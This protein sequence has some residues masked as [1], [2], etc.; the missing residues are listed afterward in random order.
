MV[1]AAKGKRFFL[2]RQE[3]ALIGVTMLW[4]GTFLVVHMAMRHSGPMFF[5][6]FRFM[7]AA[8]L[9]SLV[10]WR[11]VRDITLLEI[12]AGAV[13][14]IGIFFGYGLQTAGL[15]T[16]TSSQSAFITALYVPIVPLLQWAFLRKV[17]G[18]TSW[19]G[20]GLAFLGLMLLSG[21]GMQGLHFSFGEI[22][23]LL[24]AF[25]IALEIILIGLF[26]G[27][28]DSRRV[29]IVQLFFAA[30]FAFIA[31]PV[32]GESVPDFSWN[33]FLAGLG[34]A[35]MTALIQLTMN[36]A[37]RS[38]SPTRATIIYAGEPVWAGVVGRIAG[39]RLP[40]IALLG[41]LFILF[42]ILVSE[43]NVTK[44]FRKSKS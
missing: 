14:G 22:L 44:W 29:T 8:V 20:A 1:E 23:T 24:S 19:I 32:T 3:L 18:L 6:G 21:Q 33:W 27:R 42:G 35:V 40:A 11:L 10:F 5:V 30:I 16:I 41:A 26:A 12:F 38:I 15:Q 37:Q 28:V 39:E 43:L 25:S 17:P 2:S 7:T 31:M 9:C 34:L 13:I 4:G 36:W